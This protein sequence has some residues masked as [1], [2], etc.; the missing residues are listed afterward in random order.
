MPSRN[1]RPRR[2]TLKRK[3]VEAIRQSS[4]DFVAAFNNRDARAVAALWTEDGDYIDD[5]GQAFVGRA[6]IEREYGRFF[7]EHQEVH[8]RIAIDSLRLLSESAAI[9]DGRAFIDPPGAGAPAMSKYT[10]VH[11]LSNG[12]WLMSTVRD[13]R[14]ETASGYQNVADL[15]WL[16][17]TWTAEEHGAKTVSV[18]R[19]V[20]NKS[21][22]ERSYTVT[23][24]D[25]TTTSGVQIIGFN[26]QE[27]CVQAWNFSPD[28][29]HFIGIWTRR[30]GGWA[31]E[32]RGV[33]GDGTRTTATNLL[34]R[35]D[36][37]AYAWESINRTSGDEALP[38]TDEVVL[39][40][41][42]EAP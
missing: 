32:F 31:A 12:K 27:G 6:D 18:C 41:R 13:T 40:R 16:I 21:F 19:W 42:A 4:R 17:G 28:G 35:L 34:T 22:I 11:V 3:S 15:E 33:L 14:E 7:A 25:G 2:S 37:N 38:D 8:M 20:A 23:L 10:A 30:E 26:P 24:P 5:L 1:N 36:E 39:K 9:E 29:G